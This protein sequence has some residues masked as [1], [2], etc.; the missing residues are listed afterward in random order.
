MASVVDEH[1]PSSRD[2]ESTAFVSDS[3]VPTH[4]CIMAVNNDSLPQAL[5]GVDACLRFLCRT[6]PFREDRNGMP[7]V[8]NEKIAN[9]SL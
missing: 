9:S 6:L 7:F 8:A 4:C 3:N 1:N 2:A 5:I